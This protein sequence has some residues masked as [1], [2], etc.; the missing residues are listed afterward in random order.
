MASDK[1]SLLGPFLRA[2]SKSKTNY[3]VT[4][5]MLLYWAR[6]WIGPVID[7]R[8]QVNGTLWNGTW[9]TDAVVAALSPLLGSLAIWG[10]AVATGPLWP[11]IQSAG[12]ALEQA[13]EQAGQQQAASEPTPAVPSETPGAKS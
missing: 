13:I 4:G 7:W 3:G 2:A 10:R 12:K 9:S 8:L 6:W 11:G 1:L 5:L